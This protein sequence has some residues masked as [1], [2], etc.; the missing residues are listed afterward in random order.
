MP[1]EELSGEPLI[2][3][4]CGASNTSDATNCQ[5]CRTPL[6]VPD[7]DF[8]L[9][10]RPSARTSVGQVR[11]NNEDSLHLWGSNGILVALIADGMG[12][13][14]AGEIASGI[15]VETVNATFAGR[16]NLHL[17]SERDLSANLAQ[18][19]RDANRAVIERT[20]R[21]PSLK[22]MGTTT[23]LALIRAN[24][25]LFA[26]V[27]DSR[28]Y[29][30]DSKA[31]Q[32]TQVTHDHS[33]VQALVASGHITQEQAQHHPMGNVLYRALGQ[34]PDLEVDSYSQYLF[35]GDRLV[36]CSDGLTRHVTPDDILQI[37]L[38]EANPN[39]ASKKL[40]ELANKRGGEDNVSAIVIKIAEAS[41]DDTIAHQP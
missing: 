25:A 9:L 30:I 16:D 5:K 3:L 15:V 32:I 17:L 40:I 36:I 27:G 2:C 22:G 23:T 11:H 33:F 1:S 34:S 24:R 26:H 35:A 18:A 38:N 41:T 28:A 20:Q 8:N 39:I 7:E 14:A 37:T 29:H 19:V 12:G 10:A 21:D 31:R 4:H 13:A 6:I